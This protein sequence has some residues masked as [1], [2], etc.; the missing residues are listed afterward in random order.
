MALK[1]RAA[2]FSLLAY[3]RKKGIICQQPLT[4]S[5]LQAARS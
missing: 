1:F 2:G 4:N 5:Q 3:G